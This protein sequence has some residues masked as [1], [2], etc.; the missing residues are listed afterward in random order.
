MRDAT[1][2]VL[3]ASVWFLLNK[4][5]LSIEAKKL[6]NKERDEQTEIQSNKKKNIYRRL[7]KQIYIPK[8]RQAG[9]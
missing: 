5:K 2:I 1:I 6:T 9:N 8:N 3:L 4:I 7:D